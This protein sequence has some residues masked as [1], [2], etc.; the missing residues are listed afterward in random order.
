MIAKIKDTTAQLI[1][2]YQNSSPVKTEGDKS[3]G[4]AATTVAAE[5]VELSAKAKDFQRIRQTLD[6]IPDVRREKIQELKDQIESG[7]YTV[8]PGKVA[9]KMVSES[10]I[11]TIV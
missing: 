5:R 4:G 11:D 6:R 9:A 3:I 2:Q 7:K 1:Q 8:D 10:L